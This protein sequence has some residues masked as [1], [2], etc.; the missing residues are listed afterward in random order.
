MST[1][2]LSCGPPYL[3]I[4]SRV[5]WLNWELNACPS[6][7]FRRARPHLGTPL[8]RCVAHRELTAGPSCC[9][10]MA[11]PHL[12]TPLT[13]CTANNKLT[14]APYVRSALSATEANARRARSSVMSALPWLLCGPCVSR[15]RCSTSCPPDVAFTQLQEGKH[16]PCARMTAA[17][18]S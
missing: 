10:R 6:G 4:H 3:G 17:I 16:G 1:W 2:L 12:G 11:R 7:C 5:S 13:R 9:F 8:T 18:S 14:Q 15:R